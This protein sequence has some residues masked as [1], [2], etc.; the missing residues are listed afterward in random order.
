MTM[1]EQAERCPVRH[2]DGQL[3]RIV[4]SDPYT[5]IR[6]YR[7]SDPFWSDD[8]PN[9]ADGAWVV[10]KFEHISEIQ[11]DYRTFTH[12]TREPAFM[13]NPL[14]PS[15][16]DPPVQ[17]KLRA[18]ILPLLSADKIALLEPRMHEVCRT[19]IGTFKLRGHCE[20]ISDFSQRYPIR[21]FGDLYGLPE[22]RREEFRQLAETFLHHIEQRGEAWMAIQGIMRDELEKRRVHPQDDMLNG[23]AHGKIDDLRISIDV[24]VNLAS[25][26]FVG[27]LDTLPSNIGWTLRYL[28]DN[29]D[30]RRLLVERPELIP[31][32]V[33]EF[34]RVFPSVVRNNMC[35]ATRDVDFHGATIKAGDRVYTWIALANLDSDVFEDPLTV[36]FQRPANKHMA[37][38]VGSHRCLGSHLARHELGVALQEWL[39]AIPN[40]RI[41]DQAAVQYSGGG[42][43]S[44]RSL[45][46][47]WATPHA[48]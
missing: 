31:G 32:A 42:I 43:Y 30:Q 3:N 39:A 14:M 46:L 34:F 2:F 21:I 47:V 1:S 40:F 9:D 23:I 10:T 20:A 22:D 8:D 44:L 19:L 24:A 37:F 41:A 7:E 5:A 28:A 45:P 25:T 6:D 48:A 36:D 35:Y 26:V 38:S 29:D 16:F 13:A 18:I 11:K 4:P 27:G 17:T 12:A 15:F 33:E